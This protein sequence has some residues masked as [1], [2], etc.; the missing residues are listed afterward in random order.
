MAKFGIVP[1]PD[2]Y[3]SGDC[4]NCP[5]KMDYVNDW[6]QWDQ[7]CPLYNQEDCHLKVMNVDPK[8]KRRES[9]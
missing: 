1:L 8:K 7:G 5:I 3:K 6:G 4:N 9:L 2:D